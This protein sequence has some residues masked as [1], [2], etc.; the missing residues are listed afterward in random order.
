MFIKISKHNGSSLKD[1]GFFL[2]QSC[3]DDNNVARPGKEVYGFLPVMVKS[4]WCPD[5]KS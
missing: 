4:V 5:Y 3:D 1:L 2:V